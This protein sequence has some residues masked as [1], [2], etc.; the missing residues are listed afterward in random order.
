MHQPCLFLYRLD[1]LK[2]S[3]CPPADWATRYRENVAPGRHL[4][5]RRLLFVRPA[6]SDGVRKTLERSRC[7]G[8]SLMSCILV[9]TFG[10]L[11]SFYYLTVRRNPTSLLFP[12]PHN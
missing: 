5:R 3:R 4:A 6:F 7:L 10:F 12:S 1:A 9:G 11:S 2:S 8:T